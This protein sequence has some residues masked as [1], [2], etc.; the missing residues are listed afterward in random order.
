[1][2]MK[3]S[4]KT[5]YH[6]VANGYE[7]TGGCEMF[8][9][10]LYGSHVNDDLPEK[11]FTFAGD[12][13]IFM[14]AVTDW[15]KH[16]A[17]HY[18]K[19]GV[20]M[21]GLALTPGV[22]MPHFYSDNIDISSRWF[23]QAED[24]RAVFRNGWMEYELQQFSPWFPD[25]KVEISAYPLLPEDG[26]LVHYNIHTD[27]RVIF[28]AGFG[29]VSDF[30]G[31]FEYPQAQ[32]RYFH[33]SDCVGNKITCGNNRALVQDGNGN[34]LWIASSFPAEFSAASAASM[35]QD[36]PSLFLGSQ[37]DDQCNSAVKISSPI[38]AGKTLEGYII[39]LRNQPEQ[40]LEKWLK[41]ANPAKYIRQQIYL[42]NSGVSVNTPS[43]M[44]NQTIP[45]T[46]IA[47]DASW[48][49]NTF[50][51][52]AHG[53][54]SPFLGWR[55]WYGPNVI[56]WHD[57][58][59]TA[60][61][62]HC[63]EIPQQTGSKEVVWYDGGDR[64]D[65]DHEGT[66]YHQIKNSYGYIPCF[67]GANDIYNMQEVALDM[68]LHHLERT[69]DLEL[70]RKLFDDLSGMLDWEER[71]F[72]P[73]NDG[74]YQ[75]FLNTWISDGHSYNGGGCAQASSYN[76]HANKKMA[77]IAE[78]LNLPA[79][80]FV[81]RAQ[82]ILDAI[83]QKLWLPENGVIAEYIDTIGN[84][85]VHPSPELSTIYLAIDCGVVDMFQACQ[86]LQFT[87]NELRNEATNNGDGRLVYSSNWYPKKYSTCGLF[88][89]ENIHLALAYFKSGLK[90][91]ALEIMTALIG[92]Y[93]NG[94]NPGLIPH[95]L[96]G[97]GAD[98]I[99]DLDFSD[100]SSMYLR[101]V[102]EGLFGIRFQLL[103]DRIEIAPGFP[104]DWTHAS[105]NLADISMHYNRDGRQEAF[106]ISSKRN[107]RLRLKISMR[108]S[109]IE[110][111]LVNGLPHDYSIEAAVGN[112]FVIIATEAV[113]TLCVKLFHGATPTPEI[114]TAPAE[115]V[116]GN[117]MLIRTSA[118][119]IIECFDNTQLL[120]N[121]SFSGRKIYA[122]TADKP[123]NYTLFIRV[124]SGEYESYLPY[125]YSIRRKA[126]ENTAAPREAGDFTPVDISRY[127]NCSLMKLHTLEYRSPRPEGY[128]IGMRLNS[129]YAWE[130]NHCGHN[131]VRTDDRFLTENGY[132]E[133]PS[134]IRF[135]VPQS[136]DNI[137]CVSV[138]DNFPTQLEIPL[139]GKAD[140]LAILFIGVTNPMQSYVENARFTVEYSD[141]TKQTIKLVHPYNFDD[142][143]V[144][145]LQQENE[146]VYF[147]DY[148]HGTVQKIRLNPEK[149]LAA[150]SIQAT[151]NEVITG[152]VRICIS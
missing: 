77:K 134:G 55:N 71:I 25:V 40:V 88:P 18:A 111:V 108:S 66:Q 14:G 151:A 124:K 41:K 58:V 130:W 52:G 132:I 33:A 107:S 12:L 72:D 140:E 10:T 79:E 98:D 74:L 82:K 17:C 99:G 44:F 131:A 87:R 94:R 93:F 43:E 24:V 101:L 9:R 26:Y 89:A 61:L 133:S 128:S 3:I 28:C 135:E 142:W 127:M 90:N 54:H 106:S 122:A 112:C 49:K 113:E 129:R 86:M 97:K 76:Y 51:H 117:E 105:I 75:N 92:C 63:A 91:E 119:E 29:G 1:M 13:P 30:I 62:S 149:E 120:N 39:V 37:A 84:K 139:T 109:A 102:V 144:P 121:I 53:Y 114:I 150:L 115:I 50:C 81:V 116:A 126:A 23:H 60:I 118:G 145:A 57:R 123:G 15:S 32:E 11:F 48:H 83:L 70:A 2:N 35:E 148:N 110:A 47:M 21:S 34:S 31:R 5:R 69:G 20:L 4:A 8:N 146:T 16:T 152:L 64:P 137:A 73:D 27:Q 103:D 6:A 46:V 138:W 95:V 78:K 96:T 80:K 65:L 104:K 147:N 56:G 42:K 143:L 125:N 38:D 68:I 59:R 22:N 141:G 67:L 7:T 36:P 19:N 45:P 136:G 100:V 85:L